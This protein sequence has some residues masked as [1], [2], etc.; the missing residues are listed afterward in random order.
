MR[1]PSDFRDGE[2]DHVQDRDRHGLRDAR[3]I[4]VRGVAGDGEEVRALALQSVCHVDQHGQGIGA[5]A[6]DQGCDARGNLRVVVDED[7]DVVGV[8]LRR[9]RSDDAAQEIDRRLRSHAADDA[10]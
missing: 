5:G 2:R 1:L 9:R 3:Q 4:I 8:A 10:D 7:A 6:V